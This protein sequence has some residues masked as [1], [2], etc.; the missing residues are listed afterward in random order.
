MNYV[1]V[2]VGSKT[3]SCKAQLREPKGRGGGGPG[4]PGKSGKRSEECL[5]DNQFALNLH[6]DE[7]VQ[8]RI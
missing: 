2:V 1:Q 7:T 6:K 8:V 4:T 5:Q 3:K